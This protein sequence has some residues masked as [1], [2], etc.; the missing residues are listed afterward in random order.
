MIKTSAP[1]MGLGTRAEEFSDR[2]AQPAVRLPDRAE[3]EARVPEFAEVE[4]GPGSSQVGSLD[5]LLNVTC[6]V[7]A[8][9]GRLKLSIG[10]VLKMTIGS[11]LEL[12]RQVTD[13]VDVLVQGVRVARGEVVVVNDHFA[14]RIK[15]IVENKKKAG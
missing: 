4:Q 15:E 13:P 10:E 11:V 1:S 12:N 8:E 5:H 6:T 7:T 14:I 2:H 9:L 3:V